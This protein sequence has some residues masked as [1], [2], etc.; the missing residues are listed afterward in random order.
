MLNFENVWGK[1]KWEKAHVVEALTEEVREQLFN[2][3][4]KLVR[5]DV[6]M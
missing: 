5:C 3:H 6:M 2:D 4:M 1:K